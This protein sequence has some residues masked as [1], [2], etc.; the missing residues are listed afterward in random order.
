[1]PVKVTN[2]EFIS[3]VKDAVGDEYIPMEPYKKADVNIKFKH[4][5]CGKIFSISPN[6]F[7]H[8]GRRCAYCY[9]G[10]SK[11][12]EKFEKEFYTCAKGEYK[13][14]SKYHRT[15]DKVKVVHLVCG[16]VYLVTP[17]AF[18]QGERCPKCFGNI[19]KTTQTFNNEVAKLTNGEY[20]CKTSYVNSRTD[21]IMEHSVC[22]HLYNV[23]PHDFLMGNR[24]PYCKQSK[25]EKLVE[26]VL[27]ST[28]V[29]YEIQKVFEDCGNKNQ[30]LPFDF[31][32]KDLRLLIEYDGVQHFKPVKYYGG[33]KKLNDQKRRDSVK[34]DYAVS[35][36]LSVLRIP[37]NLA[38]DH[39]VVEL[40]NYIDKCKAEI[41]I[42]KVEYM[43]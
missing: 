12:P 16:N 14:L 1:M 8:D 18:I 34:N 20:I 10:N 32:L 4:T 22:G 26:S 28:G 41:L 30:W 29:K 40:K 25:G 7:L 38:Q 35:H 5:L 24:C 13:L 31:Y 39:V 42:P 6:H 37:Y 36:G 11:S 27:L 23:R 15:H 9:H 33:M 2:E 19:R 21:V 43:I 3:R 17:H